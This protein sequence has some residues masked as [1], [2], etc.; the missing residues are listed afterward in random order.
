MDRWRYHLTGYDDG[1]K[2]I[3]QLLE[4]GF[5]LGLCDDPS[6]TLVSSLSNHGSAYNYYPWWDEFVAK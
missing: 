4:F 1:L 5:P 2:E 6:P 3:L